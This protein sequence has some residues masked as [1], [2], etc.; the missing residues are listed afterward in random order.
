MGL[1]VYLHSYTHCFSVSQDA[2]AIPHLTLKSFA[3]RDSKSLEL[4]WSNFKDT[5]YHIFLSNN[6][7]WKCQLWGALIKCWHYLNWKVDPH[8]LKSIHLKNIDIRL[9]DSFSILSLSSILSFVFYFAILRIY[10]KAQFI[11]MEALYHWAMFLDP[12]T[13][14]YFF[15]DTCYY[16]FSPVCFY[17]IQ[18]P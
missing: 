15:K 1:S 11:A 13:D 3:F 17:Y 12:F 10:P 8:P 2:S 9:Y 7:W 4:R 5:K 6:S 18:F 14:I 16:S